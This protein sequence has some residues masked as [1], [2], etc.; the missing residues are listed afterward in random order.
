[1]RSSSSNNI[2]G[3]QMEREPAILTLSSRRAGV[4][5]GKKGQPLLVTDRLSPWQRGRGD[6]PSNMVYTNQLVGGRVRDDIYDILQAVAGL[7][8]ELQGHGG[9]E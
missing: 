1:M 9:V 2:S 6:S 8:P 7:Q 4:C 5:H 3:T